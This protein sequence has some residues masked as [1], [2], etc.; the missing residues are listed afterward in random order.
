MAV[1]QAEEEAT[2]VATPQ[3]TTWPGRTG[4]TEIPIL[5]YQE[6]RD[7]HG[8]EMRGG[9]RIGSGNIARRSC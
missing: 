1:G 3:A 2:G 5:Y 7:D 6:H 9:W 8:R 4:V